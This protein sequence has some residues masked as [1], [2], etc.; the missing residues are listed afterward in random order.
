[1][2]KDFEI[3]KEKMKNSLFN[4]KPIY[5]GFDKTE[6]VGYTVSAPSIARKNYVLNRA[7]NL[8][9]K[10]E[11]NLNVFED[12]SMRLTDR[13]IIAKKEYKQIKIW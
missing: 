8:V 6:I 5:N 3:I 7:Q 4:E 2:T 9:Q 1:M 10:F 13:F 12:D 11:L